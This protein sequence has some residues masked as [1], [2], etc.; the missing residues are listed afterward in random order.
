MTTSKITLDQLFEKI[1]TPE[2][3]LE[4]RAYILAEE[5]LIQIEEAM[6]KKDWRKKNLAAALNVSPSYISRIFCS[7]ELVS[8]KML[9]RMEQALGIDFLQ[10]QKQK[11]SQVENSFNSIL[12]KQSHFNKL[13][14]NENMDALAANELFMAA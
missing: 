5:Y 13:T 6:K 9:A 10:Q 7:D 4:H 11:T 12:T 3:Q 1:N 2:L 8:F 14:S